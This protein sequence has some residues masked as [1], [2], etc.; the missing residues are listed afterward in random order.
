MVVAK[1]FKNSRYRIDAPKDSIEVLKIVDACKGEIM[2]KVAIHTAAVSIR[3]PLLIETR[4]SLDQFLGKGGIWRIWAKNDDK[5]QSLDIP[6]PLLE[7]GIFIHNGPDDS[8]YD[9]LN[10]LLMHEV[11]DYFMTLGCGDTLVPAAADRVL[12]AVIGQ[13]DSTLICFP[14]YHQG[15]KRILYPSP[16]ELSIRMA[17]PHPST[18]LHTNSVKCVG[19][20]SMS[21]QI[22]ADYDLMCR[23]IKFRPRARVE[24]GALVNYLS[25]GMSE[26][27]GFEGMVEEELIRH[28]VWGGSV[29]QL[30][31]S[32]SLRCTNILH[33]R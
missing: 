8:L 32:L 1:N 27:R 14:L 17:C 6:M 11:A 21:Y 10:K 23:L 12:N 15:F 13:P 25:G 28:R 4:N 30:A 22:A 7:A 24:D 5:L 3:D 20:Y 2:P 18:L 31:Y 29:A 33:K 16:A 19:G 9:A 26:K